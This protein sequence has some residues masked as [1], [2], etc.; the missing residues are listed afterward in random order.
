MRRNRATPREIAWRVIPVMVGN[1]GLC[2]TSGR[3]QTERETNFNPGF[4][5]VL[6][7]HD[8]GVGHQHDAQKP[9]RDFP[10]LVRARVD[11]LN[12]VDW[13]VRALGLVPGCGVGELGFGPMKPCGDFSVTRNNTRVERT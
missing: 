5:R 2:E 10:V 7:V 12:S 11:R 8:V 3:L 6:R 9:D 13:V 1:L 4:A